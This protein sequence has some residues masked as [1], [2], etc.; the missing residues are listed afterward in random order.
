MKYLMQ[1]VFGEVL[2]VPMDL[3]SEEIKHSLALFL[4]DHMFSSRHVLGGH[5]QKGEVA[6]TY[7]SG[8]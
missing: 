6:C 1:T 4:S 7:I 5:D 3:C 2:M 8:H